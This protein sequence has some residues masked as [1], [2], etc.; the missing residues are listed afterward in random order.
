M[1]DGKEERPASIGQPTLGWDPFEVWR[2]RVKA[3]AEEVAPPS[4]GSRV[5]LRKILTRI[6][7]K[8]ES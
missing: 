4:S 5:R 1:F 7:V 6:R 3:V 2:T 8:S